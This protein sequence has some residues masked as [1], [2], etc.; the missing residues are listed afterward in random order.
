MTGSWNCRHGGEG[1]SHDGEQSHDRFMELSVEV[2]MEGRDSHMT[3]DQR[4][5]HDKSLGGIG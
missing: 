4:Q 2:S 1:K 3:G 5:S